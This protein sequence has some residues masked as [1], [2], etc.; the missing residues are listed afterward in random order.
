MSAACAENENIA[1]E[2]FKIL[3]DK[4]EELIAALNDKG[5]SVA[6][7]SALTY[8]YRSTIFNGIECPDVDHSNIDKVCVE[9]LQELAARDNHLECLIVAQSSE[10]DNLSSRISVI[11]SSCC[12]GSEDVYDPIEQLLV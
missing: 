6:E 5:E 11:Q 7:M 3:E 4:I 2:N 1:N 8:L 10:I 9:T 12:Y